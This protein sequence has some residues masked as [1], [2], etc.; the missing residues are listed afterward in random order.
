M[1]KIFLILSLFFLSATVL[2][3]RA[4]PNCWDDTSDPLIKD[5]SFIILADTEPLAKSELLK[6][7]RQAAGKH[8]APEHYP[9][10]TDNFIMITVQAVDY[11]IGENQLTREALKK[12]VHEE[13]QPIAD[14]QGVSISCNNIVRPRYRPH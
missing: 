12:A 7:L 6:L 13:L 14:T 1:K 10:I 3:A 9:R 2:D 5:G 8:I 11:G 4:I